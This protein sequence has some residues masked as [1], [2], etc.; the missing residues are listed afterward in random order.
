MK[1][2]KKFSIQEVE[3]LLKEKNLNWDGKIAHDDTILI[4]GLKV[5]SKSMRYKNFFTHGYTCCKCGKQG[6]YFY[7]D[8][9]EKQNPKRG[10]F[11]LYSE[12]GTLITK[13]H[14]YPRSQSGKN[15]INNYQTM[16]CICNSEKGNE[17][18]KKYD[19]NMIKKNKPYI[20]YGNYKFLSFDTAVKF[21]ISQ[22]MKVN[23]TKLTDTEL[24]QIQKKALRRIKAALYEG[25]KYGNKEWKIEGVVK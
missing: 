12:D 14:I 6:S 7:L 9:D 22:I 13:D 23:T 5:Y 11:N 25:K 4:E 18:P 8:I 16:C 17:I 1:H 21:A 3:N 19:N 15:H 20:N 24:S 10:H 2:I